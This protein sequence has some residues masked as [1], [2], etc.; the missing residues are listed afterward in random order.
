MRLRP[1]IRVSRTE[2]TICLVIVAALLAVILPSFKHA[3]APAKMRANT[4]G[5]L[6]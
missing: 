4:Q 5:E 1:T 3:G 6:P 2:L